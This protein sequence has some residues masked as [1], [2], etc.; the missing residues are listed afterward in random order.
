MEW[1]GPKVFSHSQFEREER[2]TILGLGNVLVRYRKVWI[3]L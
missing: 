3:F 1:E 2:T